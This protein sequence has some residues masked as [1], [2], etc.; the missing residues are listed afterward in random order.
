MDWI[1][2]LIVTGK[3]ED[4]DESL[5]SDESLKNTVRVVVKSEDDLKKVNSMIFNSSD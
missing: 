5:R 3:V 1:Q 4:G 2:T